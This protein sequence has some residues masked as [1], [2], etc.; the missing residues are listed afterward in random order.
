MTGFYF[1][2]KIAIKF[3]LHKKFYSKPL[4]RP[5]K[6]DQKMVISFAYETR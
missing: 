3:N 2:M 6:N 4:V 5:V 1:Y